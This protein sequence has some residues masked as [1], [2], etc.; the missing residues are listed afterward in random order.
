MT[1]ELCAYTCDA[2]E[3]ALRTGIPRIELCAAPLEGGTTPS[4]GLI[5]HARR[6]PGLHLNVMIRPRGGDFL[7]TAT[8]TELMAEEIRFARACGADGVVFGLLTADGEVDEERTAQL[9]R[10]A[11]GMEV[12]FHRAFDMVR[13]Q[14][15]ALEAVIR[16]GC[17]RVLTSGGCPTAP[18]GIETLRA[19]TVQA[20]GR[21]EI[22]AGSGIGPSNARQVAASG[23]DALHFSARRQR[24]SG[25]RFRN[26]GVSMG[27]CGTI[28]EYVLT[29][30][31]E[32]IVRQLLTELGR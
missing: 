25:M 17:R 16:A 15:Q 27:G 19:L 4:A 26:P 10:E 6:L 24:E 9:V 20:A 12:T 8:E 5:R 1:T 3:V 31:D 23:V 22:M 14:R 30:A 29:D 13:D 28:P 21:I 32:T 2:C 11:E 18:E 7:Y